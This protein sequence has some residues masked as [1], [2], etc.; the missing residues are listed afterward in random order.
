MSPDVF[1]AHLREVAGGVPCDPE[2]L[3]APDSPLATPFV[4]RDRTI[5][6]RWCIHPMEG[7]DGGEDGTPT[8][9]TRRRWRHFGESGAKLIWGGEA[10]AVT[11]D[12]RANPNQLVA[13]E[14]TLGGL[15]ELRQILLEAH[16]ERFGSTDDL[17]LGLQLTHSGRFARPR[18]SGRPEPRVAY[19]HPI[20]DRRFG[21]ERDEQV[22]TDGELE[23][24]IERFVAGA[25]FAAELGYDFVDVKNCHGYL[26]HEILGGCTREGPYG[27]ALSGRTRFLR[28]V[29]EG[30]RRDA[31]ALEIGVRLS[32][33]DLVPY[34][35]DP[36]TSSPGALGI[37]VPEEY[38][39][40]AGY[41]YGFGVDRRDP[42]KIDLTEA[43][44]LLGLLEKLD[45]RL[46]NISGG[47][48]YY[49][50][51]AQRPALYP[52]SDGYLPPEDPLAGVARHLAVTR[53]L[54]RAAPGLVLVGSGLSYLQDY[55]VHVAQALVR[56]EWMDFVGIGRMVLSYWDLPA[57]S[58][59]HGEFD[60][61]RICRTFSD[62]TT[63]PRHGLRSGCYPLDKDYSRLPDAAELRRVKR[64]GGS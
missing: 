38:D 58:L 20:L 60:R 6:N 14:S 49:N 8:E 9:W 51:H 32:A 54:K 27:G 24:L 59:A 55:L 44:E 15:A 52:P 57:D 3:P 10:V 63:A 50:P 1:R 17:L 29:I 25:R 39:E 31:P 7:W 13:D 61:R 26:L 43:K 18:T 64:A 62:C 46:V 36:A 48:P 35:P 47:S 30:I 45:V 22:L 34:R 56:E 5:G 2:I 28:E 40:A 11:F 21:V 37:G 16:G 41:P 4:H 23:G 12:G 42:T 33:F 53:E 19:R